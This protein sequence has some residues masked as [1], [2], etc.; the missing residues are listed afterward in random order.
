MEN[1]S[2]NGEAVEGQ[3]QQPSQVTSSN[4]EEN[5]SNSGGSANETT[6]EVDAGGQGTT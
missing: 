4:G 5:H 3:V 1:V 6:E 2:G